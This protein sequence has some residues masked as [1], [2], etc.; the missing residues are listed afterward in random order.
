MHVPTHTESCGDFLGQECL[1]HLQ[2]HG[3][4]NSRDYSHGTEELVIVPDHKGSRA[5][6]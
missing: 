6:F 4:E 3:R 5:K 1:A 2:E